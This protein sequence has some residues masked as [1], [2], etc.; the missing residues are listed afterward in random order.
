VTV[1]TS[2]RRRLAL[3]LFG[4][5]LGCGGLERLQDV[6]DSLSFEGLP[7]ISSLSELS[8]LRSVG[9][10]SLRYLGKLEA[11]DGLGALTHADRLTVTDNPLL[12]SLAPLL[13][14]SPRV[15]TQALEIGANPLLS[16]CQVEQLASNQATDS[17]CERCTD[18]LAGACP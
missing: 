17:G 11:L 4:L 10:L 2:T 5:A 18:N 15:V 14:W 7:Q 8:A 6:S 13:S 3:A 16:Q 9:H 12:S 1:R